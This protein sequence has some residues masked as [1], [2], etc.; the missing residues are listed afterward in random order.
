MQLT[1]ISSIFQY[2]GWL[3]KKYNEQ[4]NYQRDI[5]RI[6]EVKQ[7]PSG[8]NKIVIQVIGKSVFIECTPQEIVVDDRM[9]EGFS[10]KDIRTI[11]YF[12]CEQVKK[13]K[14]KIVVQE[15]CE[16]FNRIVFKLKMQNDDNIVEKTA[17]QVLL[18]KNLV[19]GLSR[20]DVKSVSYIAGYEHSQK[21][22]FV[23]NNE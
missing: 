15:F 8:E 7:L 23:K 6:A 17:S 22:K 3:L 18:D 9:L 5:Y 10:K 19:D 20:E 21:E 4:Q 11:T 16:K 1:K 12:A 14:Y 13:P 2:T